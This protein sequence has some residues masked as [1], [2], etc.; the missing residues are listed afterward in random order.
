MLKFLFIICYSI[1]AVW[2]ATRV[3]VNNATEEFEAI[4]YL[5]YGH[6]LQSERFYPNV[7]QGSYFF[8]TLL[9]FI[10]KLLSKIVPK[11]SFAQSSCMFTILSGFKWL[12][13]P[14]GAFLS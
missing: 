6:G 8:I 4:H 13:S 1:L 14:T 11:V 2:F 12:F 5:I 10:P 7:A 3:S 9:A